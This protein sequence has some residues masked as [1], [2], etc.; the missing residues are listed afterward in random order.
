MRDLIVAV[1]IGTASARA[2]VFDRGG[3]ML[4]RA[5][6]P[7]AMR[8]P[9]ENH[10]DHDSEDIWR[11]VCASVRE[12]C[13]LA[14]VAAGRV[15]A[16]GFDATCSLVVR[17]RAGRPL[18]V[19]EDGDERWDTIVWLDHRA[20]AEADF[21]TATR[22]PALLHAGEVMS[23]E[24]QMPKLMWL[25]RNRPE[26]WA[27]AGYFF[28]LADFVTWRATGSPARSR[29]TTTAKWNYLAHEAQPWNESFLAAIGL[30]DLT[31]RGGLPTETL[32]A[33]RPV[34]RL[35][36]EAA[37]ELGLDDGVVAGAGLIDAYAGALGVLGPYAGTP[38]VLER[39]FALVGG[40][41]SC[42][43]A[44]SRQMKPGFGL[45]GP[46]YEAALPGFWLMEG[47]QSAAGALLD[48]LVRGHS[49]GGEPTA[50]R[51]AEIV[52]R[53]A[54]LRREEGA[55]FAARLHVLPDFHG[56]RSPFGD[57][58]ALGV[59]SGL[60][61]D[62]SFDGLCRLYWR[63]AIAIALGIR[64]VLEQFEACGYAPEALH[65]TGGHLRN[66]LLTELYR[67]VTGRPLV[68]T[69][70]G[71]G[72][73][74]GTAMTAA[75]AGGL[76]SDLAAAGAAMYPGGRTLFPDPGRKAG[77]DRDYR[78]FLTLHRHRRELEAIN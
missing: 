34:G 66:P 76:Y 35:T 42:I 46:Y 24:M 37:A 67:D 53:I 9:R 57:P 8:R 32:P 40:T 51:H 73:L 28:D 3:A 19:S 56:N 48:H 54:A 30:S 7:I 4:A 68:V 45:W 23:P 77:Y 26:Q 10:A 21:C 41:S 25:K 15:A 29:C 62:A 43:V 5:D 6:R 16:I 72:M 27:R 59:I 71:D 70:E 61:L 65:L 17:D 31:G 14:G 64:H 69:H 39:Q 18:A 49:A 36:R 75:V 63:S 12:A 44:L 52:A 60:T 55:A 74:L 38:D 20:L 2:G 22:H 78:R 47:G 50:A 58:H 13:G 11:A 1:D 33:G